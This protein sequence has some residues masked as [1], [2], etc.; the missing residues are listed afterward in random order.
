MVA[1]TE[2]AAQPLTYTSSITIITNKYL[3]PVHALHIHGFARI[4]NRKGVMP[5]EDAL[6][7]IVRGNVRPSFHSAPG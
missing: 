6:T 2:I 5:V 7:S 1:P 4:Y 3:Y